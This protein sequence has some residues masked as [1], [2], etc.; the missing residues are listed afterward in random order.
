MNG[1]TEGANIK[2][3][4]LGPLLFGGQSV[5]NWNILGKIHS[6]SFPVNTPKG[7]AVF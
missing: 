3:N 5:H 7:V 2:L 4:F 6:S 1:C